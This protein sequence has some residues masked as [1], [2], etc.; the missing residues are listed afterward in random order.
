MDL[1]ERLGVSVPRL[2]RLL[3]RPEFASHVHK[4]ERQ[5]ATGTRTVTLVS[6]SVIGQVEQAI[7]DQRDG[8]GEQK[9]ERLH[10][11]ALVSDDERARALV[12]MVMQQAEARISE[13]S[14]ALADVRGER[15]R[16]L[17]EREH[18]QSRIEA[19]VSEVQELRSIEAQ[20]AEAVNV[21]QQVTD[22]VADQAADTA[23]SAPGSLETSNTGHYR[24][25]TAPAPTEGKK[26]GFLARLFGR[27]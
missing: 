20:K 3:K 2:Q 27:Q 24:G 11:E 5:T 18:F 16:L 13:L 21:A 17:E 22:Q 1:A 6:V 4:G 14:T 26:P 9:R 7:R 15:N 19:L 8:T 25:E 23:T 12:G 10:A